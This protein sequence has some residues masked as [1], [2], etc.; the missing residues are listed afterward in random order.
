MRLP[1]PTIDMPDLPCGASPK[2]LLKRHAIVVYLGK[3]GAGPKFA[4]SLAAAFAENGLACTYVHAAANNYPLGDSRI[5]TAAISTYMSICGLLWRLLLAPVIARRLVAREKPT[6][7]NIYVFPMHTP[8]T[9]VLQAILFLLGKEIVS[10]VHDAVRHP[11]DPFRRITWALTWLELHTST[12]V[13]CLTPN[14]GRQCMRRYSLSAS[15]CVTLFHPVFSYIELPPRQLRSGQPVRLL[16]MGRIVRYKGLGL[17]ADAMAQ[18][19]ARPTAF[20]LTIAGDGFIEPAY[21]QI[22]HITVINRYLDDADIADL[23]RAADILVLPYIEAS[24]SGVA[25]AAAGASLPI[26]HTP[27]EGLL[28]QLQ[29]YG[30]D[31]A[32]AVD[33]T[34]LAAALQR[35]ASDSGL[36]ERLSNRQHALYRTHTWP[37]FSARLMNC[38]DD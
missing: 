14:V 31:A 19:S 29:D 21:L 7:R 34:A 13:V 30:A 16:F 20:H 10:I 24:Q 4:S 2:Q 28:E 23:L 18:L 3:S 27:V 35:V 12:R 36:Y 26:V 5:E 22:P 33:A 17:L 11:G 9:V 8:L 38:L 37:E 25:A 15:A 6:H 32:A 1:H